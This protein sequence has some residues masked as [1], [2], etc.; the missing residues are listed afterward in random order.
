M[1]TVAKRND[2]YVLDFYDH[3]G[4]RRRLTMP[5][6]TT[7]RRSSEILRDLQEQVSNKTFLPAKRVPT[8]HQVAKDWLDHKKPT[9]EHQ[10]GQFMKAIPETTS[11]NSRVSRSASFLRPKS[12]NGSV[13]VNLMKYLLPQSASCWLRWDKSLAT[14]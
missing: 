14:A 10:H 4:R 12:K 7:K 6:G 1:A 11:Q 5:K 8:F 3:E 2:K 9:F 13:S